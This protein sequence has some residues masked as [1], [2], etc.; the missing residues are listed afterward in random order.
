M[1]KLI[2]IIFVVIV[3][4]TIRSSASASEGAA[5]LA[6]PETDAQCFAVSVLTA[7]AEY[8]ILITCRGLITPPQTETLF[9][10][11]WA[12]KAPA[13]A[14]RG[15]YIF[16]GGISSGKLSA[17]ARDPFDEVIIT[18]QKE[19]SPAAPDLENIAV[20]GMIQPIEFRGTAG[21]ISNP[22]PTAPIPRV[23]LAPTRNAQSPSAAAGRGVVS[24]AFRL[25]LVI[26]GIIVVAAVA[27]SVIQ[28][29][30]AAK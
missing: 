15:A 18:A 27:I 8:R 25:F 14:S 2:T 24:T 3:F 11:A 1:K 30:S 20:K 19:N 12:K 10:I 26:I 16:L 17:R 9:Y 23:T 28:R 7:P 5:F 6:G 4:L 22:A 21:T 13:T 29:R